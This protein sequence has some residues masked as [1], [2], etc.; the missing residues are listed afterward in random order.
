[1]AKFSAL[2]LLTLAVAMAA[3][4]IAQT[5]PAGPSI[6]WYVHNLTNANGGPGATLNFTPPGDAEVALA[7]SCSAC[8]GDGAL[9][10]HAD[11]D[12]PLPGVLKASG[13]GGEAHVW[14]KSYQ[15]G[16]APGVTVTVTVFAD[17]TAIATG[18]LTQDVI[19]AT[20]EYVIPLDFKAATIASGAKLGLDVALQ[21]SHCK[22][23]LPTAYGKGVSTAYPWR[24]TLPVSDAG[25]TT[26]QTVYADLATPT[27]N[28]AWK[29]QA[30][31]NTL[32]LYNW[33]SPLTA[34][35]IAYNAEVQA[36][37][38]HFRVLDAANKT[39]LDKE[40]TANAD[41]S[42]P[43]SAA[44]SG[45]WR[46]TVQFTGFK[47]NAS[48]V[49]TGSGQSTSTSGPPP[50]GESSST[51][52]HGTGPSSSSAAGLKS[53]TTSGKGSPGFEALFVVAA[54]SAAVLA[55]RRR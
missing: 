27:F 38:V 7:I 17:S 25:A 46:V 3:P 42:L 24:F 15:G 48:L 23:Y 43:I 20:V 2:L 9:T 54:L 45:V 26:G 19:A 36:G 50:T 37:S 13:T 21:D 39:V 44:T 10:Y 55:L 53:S 47:G 8:T 11:A 51:T 12:A 52:S 35:N 29:D 28:Q 32:F 22:C 18:T 40:L 6:T 5:P 31:L 33:T 49:I 16:A 1:M 34:G 14:V 30:N 41:E 4:G